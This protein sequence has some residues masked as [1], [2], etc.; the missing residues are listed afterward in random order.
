[1]QE[2]PRAKED[3][4]KVNLLKILAFEYYSINPDVGINYSERSL[5]LAEMLNWKKG[6]ANA[7]KTLGI[8]N[9][10]IAK[11]PKA[12]DYFQKALTINEEISDKSGIASN[13]GN[14][15][16][17]YQYQSDYPKAMEYYFKALKIFEELGDKNGTTNNL[18]NIGIVY[19]YQSNYPKA[20]EYYFKAL[21][22][23]QELD[24]KNGI[25]RNLGNIGIVYK[26]QFDYPNAL[27][28]DLKAT[29]IYETL[30]NKSGIAVNSGNI[31]VI[32]ENQSDYPMALKYYFKALK[33]YEELD[34]KNGIARNLGNIGIL[35]ITLSQD[36]IF[37]KLNKRNELISKTREMNLIKG[38]EYSLKAVEICREIGELKMLINIYS[39]IYDGFKRLG[40]YPKALEY[41]E[42]FQKTQDS[43]FNLEKA[44]KFASLEAVRDKDIAV[45]QTE[46]QKIQLLKA[47]NESYFMYG[48]LFFLALIIVFIYRQR[49]ISEKL[50]LN[51]LPAK[52]SKR[53]KKKESPIADYFAEASVVFIDIVDF[54]K[55]SA[56]VPAKRVA[57]VLNILYSRLDK[58]AQKH[59]LEKI[60]TIG[61]CY[62]AAAG[63]PVPDKDNAFKAA[64]FVN[65]AYELLTDY[66]AGDGT[67]L[68]F[69]CGVDCGPVVAGVIG[70]HKFI[71]D[72]WGDTVNTAARMEEYSEPGKIQIT[73]RFK[74]AI[75]N[76]E[77][78]FTNG[79]KNFK[80]EERGEVEIKGKGVMRTWFLE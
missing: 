35:Y 77:I 37:S 53:L 6:I 80:F 51:I 34:D 57:E 19:W 52:I 17:V 5:K 30:G 63:L 36:S 70:D 73:E 78:R 76:Y 18:G 43:V 22:I 71:Y 46:I 54:T 64:K 67:I 59:G 61:D 69:R 60:K 31:G 39:S 9:W 24:D 20:M 1:L 58:I 45:K 15:G 4:N 33:I 75:T 21:K 13:L 49:K 48:G 41:H 56:K 47:R 29:E 25:A 44:K 72:V 23:Y 50:L 8:C 3:T 32:Y 66:D 42:F 79:G 28:Y 74:E 65:E 11:Y 14:I 27:K 10:S 55:M 7:L 12:L 62:M 38:I 16:I 40:N 68:Q 2:L 26:E